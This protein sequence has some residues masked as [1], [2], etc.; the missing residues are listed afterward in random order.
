MR[1]APA[2]SHQLGLPAVVVRASPASGSAGTHPFWPPPRAPWRR[3]GWPPRWCQAG[4]PVATHA[5]GR[6][7]GRRRPGATPRSTARATPAS[8]PRPPRGRAP[9]GTPPRWSAP[10]RPGAGPGART[11]RPAPPGPAPARARRRP[12]GHQRR[13]L[14]PDVGQPQRRAPRQRRVHRRQQPRRG[15]GTPAPTGSSRRWWAATTG[16]VHRGL[17]EARRRGRQHGQRPRPEPG[18]QLHQQRPAGPE[19]PQADQQLAQRQ[20]RVDPLLVVKRDVVLGAAAL[21]P[22]VGVYSRA[23]GVPSAA[24]PA[25]RPPRRAARP[26]PGG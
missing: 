22:G 6:P 18:V 12:R 9:R 14:R 17:V 4:R 26:P 2:P 16:L 24:P 8:A 21:D 25:G 10:A 1:F 7:A 11:P 5:A 15:R 19:R 3:A 13:R 20:R 23:P